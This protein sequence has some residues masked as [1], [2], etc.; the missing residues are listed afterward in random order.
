M[1]YPNGQ[2]PTSALASVPG[3]PGLTLAP[4]AAASWGRVRVDVQRRK[5]W[6]PVLTDAYRALDG[7]YGQLATFLRRYTLTYSVEVNGPTRRVKVWQ[8]RVYYLRKGAATAATPGTSNHGIGVAVDVTGLGAFDS[9]RYNDFADVALEH[10]WDNVEGHGIGEAWHWRY[11]PENDRHRGATT[12]SNPITTVS[13]G[14]PNPGGALPTPLDREDDDM[15]AAGEQAILEALGAL[16][17]KVAGLVNAI[18]VGPTAV[19]AV[20]VEARDH[21]ANAAARAQMTTELA[22]QAVNGLNDG[23]IGALPQLVRLRGEVA[24]ITAA[25]TQV[26]TGN[27]TPLDVAAITD[28]AERGARDALT[29]LTLTAKTGA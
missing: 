8:D 10:G 23:T 2:W 4:A 13:I 25:L 26:A 29:N 21:A 22:Q 19:A 7:F 11:R 27:G 5:G 16:T 3:Q 14:V 1:V 24:G 15:S 9:D 28:A 12:V 20:G 6:T 17:D 18:Q